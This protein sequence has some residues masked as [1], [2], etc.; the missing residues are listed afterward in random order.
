MQVQVAYTS[1]IH[2]WE[3]IFFW[4]KAAISFP[5]WLAN[6]GCSSVIFIKT[7][8]TSNFD[9]DLNLSSKVHILSYN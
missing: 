7:S 1:K 8:R 2:S 4:C 5:Q 6:L 3:I 9:D